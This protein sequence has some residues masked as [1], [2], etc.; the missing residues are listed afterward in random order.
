MNTFKP[1]LKVQLPKMYAPVKIKF[2]SLRLGFGANYGVI[3]DVDTRVERKCRRV[4]CDGGWK[5]QIVD[6][7][8]LR[9]ID[10]VAE[11]DKEILDECGSGLEFE[12]CA[13]LRG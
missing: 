10:Y 2:W 7:L 9:L 12:Y 13:Q 1:Q 11:Q 8:K 6:F 3:F 5:W 4:R